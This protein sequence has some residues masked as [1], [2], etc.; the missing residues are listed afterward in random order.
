M[1]WKVE[2]F[3]KFLS[4]NMNTVQRAEADLKCLM[5]KGNKVV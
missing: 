4:E 1:E 2:N 3:L 5:H